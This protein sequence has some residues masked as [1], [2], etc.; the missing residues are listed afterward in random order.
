MKT[1][2]ITIKKIQ[3]SN[4]KIQEEST[5]KAI[6]KVSEFI[7]KSITQGLSIEQLFDEQPFYQYQARLL[8][9]DE[10]TSVQISKS[11]IS[12]KSE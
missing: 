10:K 6:L 8:H 5:N 2:L 12:A 1:Y 9:D 3:V 7:D 4:M 11:Y